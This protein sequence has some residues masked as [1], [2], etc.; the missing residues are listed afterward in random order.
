MKLKV[1]ISQ[2][3]SA[4]RTG[5]NFQTTTSRVF[6]SSRREWIDAMTLYHFFFV[7]SKSEEFQNIFPLN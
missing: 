2:I 5:P 4:V 3:V 7:F 1:N 6:L